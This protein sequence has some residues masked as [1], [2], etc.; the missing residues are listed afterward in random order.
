MRYRAIG[1]AQ[2]EQRYQLTVPSEY[3]KS[4][5]FISLPAI[6]SLSPLLRYFSR[7][8]SAGRAWRRA[9]FQSRYSCRHKILARPISF[10]CPGQ[11]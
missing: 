10:T 4:H 1:R 2:F 3:R 5:H 7:K 9:K 6:A 8:I 11:Q